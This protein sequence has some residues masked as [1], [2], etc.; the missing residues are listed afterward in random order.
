[1]ETNLELEKCA[2]CNQFPDDILML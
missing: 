2:V 1:M